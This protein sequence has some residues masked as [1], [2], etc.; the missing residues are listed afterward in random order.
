MAG[1]MDRTCG[2]RSVITSS[3]RTKAFCKVAMS[4]S[5][6]GITRDEKITASAVSKNAWGMF[7][8]GDAPEGRAPF[9]LAPGTE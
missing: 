4:I 9:A 7:V 6:P 3:R 5:L 8:V 2:S 1:D